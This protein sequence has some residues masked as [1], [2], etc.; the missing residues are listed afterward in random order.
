[1][2]KAYWSLLCYP[3]AL[4]SILLSMLCMAG[5]HTFPALGLA[6]LGFY[7]M[8]LQ[9]IW[10]HIAD[11]GPMGPGNKSFIT[12]CGLGLS[13]VITLIVG[14]FTDVASNWLV[15]GSLLLPIV[16]SPVSSACERLFTRS[17]VG[18]AKE[19]SPN[20]EQ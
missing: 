15:L 16:A 3:L 10:A 17:N 5:H 1:M 12:V 20:K 2:R 14:R 18:A 7:W 4:V 8:L 6:I 9:P 13:L 11:G 19:E